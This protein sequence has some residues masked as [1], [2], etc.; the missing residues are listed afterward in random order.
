MKMPGFQYI[1][2]TYNHEVD[3]LGPCLWNVHKLCALVIMKLNDIISN[4]LWENTRGTQRFNA[5]R[6]GDV[7][8]GWRSA[9]GSYNPG[10]VLKDLTVECVRS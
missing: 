1:F 2:G 4:R 6:K 9:A 7:S 8:Y 3:Y 5:A 10:S